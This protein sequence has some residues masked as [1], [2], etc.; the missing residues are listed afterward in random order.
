[1]RAGQV[2]ARSILKRVHAQF[3]FL[4]QPHLVRVKHGSRVHHA[5]AT[6]AA[7]HAQVCYWKSFFNHARH[8]TRAPGATH[9][10]AAI[11]AL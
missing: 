9:C 2:K 7:C 1:L 6:E 10:H 11:T 4:R 3:E 5:D 8:L